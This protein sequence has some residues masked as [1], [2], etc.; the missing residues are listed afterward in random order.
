MIRI[1]AETEDHIAAREALLDITMGPARHQK[2]SQRLRD[3]RQPA[4][5]LAF[6]ALEGAQGKERLVGTVRLW[7]INAGPRHPALLLG[8]LATDFTVRGR[9]LGSALTQHAIEEAVRLGHRAILLVGDAP[10]YERFGFSAELTRE[11]TMPGAYDPARFLGLEMVPGALAG[12]KGHVV[13]TSEQA[14]FAGARAARVRRKAR[15]LAA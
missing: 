7:H 12:A 5:G 11:L 4:E 2:C 10:F 6:S 3:F 13:P 1:V 15:A 14:A 9:G 8:P